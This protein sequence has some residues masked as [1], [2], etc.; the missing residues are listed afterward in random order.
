MRRHGIISLGVPVFAAAVLGAWVIAPGVSPAESAPVGRASGCESSAVPGISTQTI[1][2]QGVA[3]Q[4]RVAVP[5]PGSG[6]GLRPL[7]L[8]FHG[9]G[10]DDATQANYSELEEKGSARGFVVITPNAGSPAFWIAPT[11]DL[12]PEPINDN[13]AFTTALV[14]TAA[15]ELCIDPRRVYVTG[16]SSGAGMSAY[17]GCKLSRQIAAIAPVAGV[18]LVASCPHGKPISVVAFHGTADPEVAYEGGSGTYVC[19][20]NI[21]QLSVEAAVRAWA[22]RAECRTKPARKSIGTDVERIAY[23][24]C[25]SSTGVVL[26][27]VANG[28][29]N[30]PGSFELDDLGLP[31]QDI[32]AADLILDFFSQH[33]PPA[34]NAKA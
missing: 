26:Y 2:V 9:A 34:K 31:T 6:K 8:N 14:D 25:G 33:P 11:P 17:L 24:G 27:K 19:C 12:S 22:Q 16:F 10:R 3:R 5:E 4:Y 21:D 18:N 30:W 32:N 7:I 23:R 1:D 15:A 20:P 29:H 13:L 28:A